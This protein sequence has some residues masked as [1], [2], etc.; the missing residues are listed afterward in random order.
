MSALYSR[1]KNRT[2]D[3][4]FLL[5]TGISKFTRLSVFSALSNLVDFAAESY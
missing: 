4:R 3:I 1:M 2:G 5:K